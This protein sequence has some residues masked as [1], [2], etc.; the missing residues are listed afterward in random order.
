MLGRRP[1]GL[2]TDPRNTDDGG[3]EQKAEKKGG[4]LWRRPGP[5]S[6]CSAI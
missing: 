6:G 3:D 1:E 5:R 2:I 4:V